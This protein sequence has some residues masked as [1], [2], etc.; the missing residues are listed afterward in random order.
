MP[1]VTA[2][3]EVKADGR[4]QESFICFSEGFLPVLRHEG[5]V[6][7]K[8]RLSLHKEIKMLK[9]MRIVWNKLK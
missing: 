9:T 5:P 1:A 3:V 7:A 8:R 4:Q 2:G 6:G